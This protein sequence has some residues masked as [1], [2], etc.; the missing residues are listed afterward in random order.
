[1]PVS[2]APLVAAGT[3]LGDTVRLFTGRQIPDRCPNCRR[4]VALE[5]T[6]QRTVWPE[7]LLGTASTGQRLQV[8][9]WKCLHCVKTTVVH[10]SMAGDEAEDIWIAWPQQEARELAFEAPDDVRSLFE[11]GSVAEAAG[12]RRGAAALYR[13]AVERLVTAQGATTGKLYHQIEALRDRVS[14]DIIDDLHEARMLGNWSLHD[15]V[16][17]SAEEVADVAELIDDAVEELYVLP[18]KRAAMR[19]ARAARREEHRQSGA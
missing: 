7:L 18:G 6:D 2:A 17:F 8:Y 16:V 5:L 15:G 14:D 3:Y 4:D 13:A 19:E 12:A 9:T 11:E 1:M 10:A